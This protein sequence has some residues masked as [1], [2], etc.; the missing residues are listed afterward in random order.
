MIVH[1]SA[2]G[3]PDDDLAPGPTIVSTASLEA[4]CAWF[5]GMT[6]DSARL[7]FRASLEISGVPTES[8]Q[9]PAFWEDRLFGADGA[10]PV[11]FRIG[12]VLFEG[13]NPCAR[14]V[15]PSRE[16]STGFVTPA[17]QRRFAERRQAALPHWAPAERFDHFY[18]MAV[19]TRV[20]ASERGKLLR[21]GDAVELM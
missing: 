6:L 8:G 2:A 11:R 16:P 12:D 5:P 3:F 9:V 4:V 18:R 10:S 7:R 17:F 13:S 19:N 15:V 1:Y 14:C 20:P 21:L